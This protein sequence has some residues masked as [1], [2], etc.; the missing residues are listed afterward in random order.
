MNHNHKSQGTVRRDT[1]I[2]SETLLKV[3]G[4]FKEMPTLWAGC[5]MFEPDI[6]D[7]IIPITDEIYQDIMQPITWWSRFKFFVFWA[8]PKVLWHGATIEKVCKYHGI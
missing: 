4:G 7:Y 6:E 1:K 8:I 5:R 3:I 2:G